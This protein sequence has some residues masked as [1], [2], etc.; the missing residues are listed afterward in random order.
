MNPRRTHES[1]RVYSLPGGN[2]DN[3]LWL[4]EDTDADGNPTRRS[5]WEPTAVERQQIFDGANIELCTW[6][7]GVPPVSLALTTVPLG[8]PPRDD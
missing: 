4:V 2:E 1:N 6:G 8:A 5:T 7:R 3:D